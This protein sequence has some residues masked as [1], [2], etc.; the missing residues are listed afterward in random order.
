MNTEDDNATL[1]RKLRKA[2]PKRNLIKLPRSIKF[3]VDGST[4]RMH[5]ASP[6][7][8]AN[9]QDNSSSFEGWALALKRWLPEVTRIEL[10]WSFDDKDHN[11][12][13][14]RFLFR[15][16]HF[17]TLFP[18]WFL[19]ASPQDAIIKRTLRTESAG[20]YFVTAPKKDRTTAPKDESQSLH[21]VRDN[22]HKLECFIMDH[23]ADLLNLFGITHMDRQFPVGVFAEE[24]SNGTE[25]FPRGHSAIDLLGVNGSELFL[26]ELKALANSPIGILSELFFY[27]YIMEGI[28]EN[29]FGI[30]PGQFDFRIPRDHI[31]A[32]KVVRAY[33]LAPEWHPLID[34]GLLQMINEAFRRGD[35]HIRFGSVRIATEESP[36]YKLELKACD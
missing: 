24:V 20:P 21:E 3:T 35:R 26:F 11:R 19:I 27:S 13:Y 14:Q 5:L 18:S 17:R 6:C 4:V 12:H 25:I 10:S 7:V 32:T 16:N 30:Q 2:C 1:A 33:V 34:E 9:M 31:T 8:K 28:Q 29:R 36:A 15:A 23:S 22:E